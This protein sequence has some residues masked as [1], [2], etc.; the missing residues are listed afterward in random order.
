MPF[1]PFAALAS[2]YQFGSKTSKL[3]NETTISASLNDFFISNDSIKDKVTTSNDNDFD[4]NNSFSIIPKY[5]S[6]VT[7]VTI[8]IFILTAS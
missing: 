1:A 8:I 3:S 2:I 5:G 4:E 7:F 6:N